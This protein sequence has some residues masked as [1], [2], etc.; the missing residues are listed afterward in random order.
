[1][2]VRVVRSVAVNVFE[3]M[4]NTHESRDNPARIAILPAQIMRSTG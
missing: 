4:M 2:T 3:D 1:M